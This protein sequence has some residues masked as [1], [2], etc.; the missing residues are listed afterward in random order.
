MEE[1]LNIDNNDMLKNQ[2]QNN[3]I[4]N[5]MFKLKQRD[6]HL[7]YFEENADKLKAK[8]ICQDCGHE[9]MKY[10]KTSHDRT[11][12]HQHSLL[13]NKLSKELEEMKQLIK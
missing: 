4:N 7:K 11:K 12:K 3:E 2:N 5:D 8:I 6:Y 13:I 10:N 1:L 9:Y